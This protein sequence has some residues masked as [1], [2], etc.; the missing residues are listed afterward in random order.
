MYFFCAVCVCNFF[1]VST[2]FC[3]KKMCSKNCS[4]QRF[5]CGKLCVK[6]P[7]CLYLGAQKHLCTKHRYAKISFIVQKPLCAKVP[8]EQ[9]TFFESS[10]PS[11]ILTYLLTSY[12]VFAF[13]LILSYFLKFFLAF[14]RGY[15]RRSFVVE[16]RRATL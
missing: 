2:F 8:S 5:L 7:M 4:V 12:L 9:I 13:S 10:P 1:S 14:Y 6:M 15:L 11:D 3:A 16:V